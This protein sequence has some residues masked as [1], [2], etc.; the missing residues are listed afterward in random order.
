MRNKKFI[1]ILVV[2]LVV[3]QMLAP[4]NIFGI[5]E[6]AEMQVVKPYQ[7]VVQKVEDSKI[8]LITFVSG[9]YSPIDISNILD[10]LNINPGNELQ[11]ISRPS[12]SVSLITDVSGTVRLNLNK[13]AASEYPIL[14]KSSNGEIIG[15]RFSKEFINENGFKFDESLSNYNIGEENKWL[16]YLK[17]VTY[18]DLVRGPI[19]VFG[20]DYNK[21][22]FK[23]EG[24]HRWDNSMKNEDY[25][26]IGKISKED[27]VKFMGYVEPKK[28]EKVENKK[29][30]EEMKN[31]NLG[32]RKMLDRSGVPTVELEYLDWI[33]HKLTA[34]TLEKYSRLFKNYK[35]K[36]VANPTPEDLA[37]KIIEEK[38][39]MV[40]ENDL[41]D[42]YF[43]PESALDDSIKNKAT[44]I[45]YNFENINNLTEDDLSVMT[46][47]V[48]ISLSN[49]VTNPDLF[50]MIISEL[51]DRLNMIAEQSMKV[52][53]KDKD[54]FD[55]YREQSKNTEEWGNGIL[56]EMGDHK[57]VNSSNDYS[58]T[59]D[60]SGLWN[61]WDDNNND[62]SL[63]DLSQLEDDKQ[64]NNMGG[65]Y[66]PFDKNND[67]NNGKDNTDISN[68]KL[69]VR[70]KE[71]YKLGRVKRSN[72]VDDILEVDASR[73]TKHGYSDANLLMDSVFDLNNQR[74]SP[75]DIP[76]QEVM[77]IAIPPLVLRNNI[78]TVNTLPYMIALFV[79]F[80]VMII[81]C[82]IFKKVLERSMTKDN[83]KQSIKFKT[84]FDE[85]KGF[86]DVNLDI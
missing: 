76:I 69:T 28:E 67:N 19:T 25:F 65:Y 24:K 38:K 40:A 74:I 18:Y 30:S 32:S 55:G 51:S 37:R 62:G 20:K 7:L 48:L 29:P 12:S 78:K 75:Y 34:E 41:S 33:P 27:R 64:G 70:E 8:T 39:A 54:N 85:F 86:E 9:E 42:I 2:T 83:L 63:D 10:K 1:S 59:D 68:R 46:N 45:H 3:I 73:L 22:D 6:K 81:G 36:V 77:A 44:E 14:V 5:E 11:I 58:N 52:T 16:Y 71:G 61:F 4:L 50:T 80:A 47:R 26:S 23:I 56:D 35:T 60:G 49:K 84:T 53:D 21:S 57:D 31:S 82:I 66:D 13:E 17:Y 79:L 72:K 15:F 43:V